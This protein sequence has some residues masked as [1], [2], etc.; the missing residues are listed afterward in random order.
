MIN[1]NQYLFI[2]VYLNGELNGLNKSIDLSVYIFKIISRE[3]QN[4]SLRNQPSNEA[5]I[6]SIRPKIEITFKAIFSS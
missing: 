4:I 3:S 6:K 2:L 5:K 1:N